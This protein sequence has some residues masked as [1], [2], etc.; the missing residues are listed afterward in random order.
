MTP[1]YLWLAD[2]V[3]CQHLILRRV[4]TNAAGKIGLQVRDTSQELVETQNLIK[5]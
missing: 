2:K 1:T 5:Y 4:R 3:P